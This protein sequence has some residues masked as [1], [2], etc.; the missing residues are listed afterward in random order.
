MKTEHNSSF[1]TFTGGIDL[2]EFRKMVVVNAY[3]RAEK[4]DF[5]LW[6]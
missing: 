2:D 6:P 5:E 3:Y 4:R 1:D